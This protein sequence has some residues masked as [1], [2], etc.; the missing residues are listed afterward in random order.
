MTISYYGDEARAPIPA[1]AAMTCLMLTN[2]VIAMTVLF[3]WT[4][5][6]LYIVEPIAWATWMPV[7]RGTTFEDL[8]EYPFVM[9]WLMPTAGIA[10]AWLA[11]KLGRRLLAISSATLPI[12]LLALIFGWYHFAPPTYL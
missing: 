4:A 6:S 12:A 8:F 9:L 11:L 5:V 2:A 3:A 1:S 10:G 7:R